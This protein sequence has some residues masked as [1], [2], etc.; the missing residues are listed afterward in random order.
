MSTCPASKDNN[1]SNNENLV[2]KEQKQVAKQKVER[3]TSASKVFKNEKA[4]EDIP[5][6]DYTGTFQPNA[7][8]GPCLR[9]QSCANSL[10]PL[11]ETAIRFF[12]AAATTT[13]RTT[14]PVCTT[15]TSTSPTTTD[16]C[17]NNNKPLL[18]HLP[19][20]VSRGFDHHYCRL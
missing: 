16:N 3:R 14:N 7:I 5:K 17:S 10:T 8:V 13:T 9:A 2:S 15:P 20:S 19:L 6:F 11:F 1:S 4:R 18:W 12:P